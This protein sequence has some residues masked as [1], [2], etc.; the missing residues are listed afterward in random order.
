MSRTYRLRAAAAW[1]AAAALAAPSAARDCGIRE[2]GGATRF[3]AP[4]D[5][6]AALRAMV[7]SHWGEITRLLDAAGWPG[8]AEDLA[9]AVSGGR[10]SDRRFAT[11]T[12]F[13]WMMLRKNGAPMLLRDDCWGGAQPFEAF[14]F[15]VESDGRLWHFVVPKACGN[16][17][18]L[19]SEPLSGSAADATDSEAWRESE[20]PAAEAAPAGSRRAYSPPRPRPWW[21]LELFAGY[22]F[23]E[24]LDED[25][26]FGLRFGQVGYGAWGWLAAASWFDVADSQGFAGEDVDADIVHVDL[27]AVY[28]PRTLPGLALFF[29][30]GWASGNVD[31]PGSTEDLSDDA[32]TVHA[33]VG[34]EFDA[35][36]RFYLKPDLRARWYELEGWGTE[37]GRE[38]QVTY[39]VALALGW[40]FGR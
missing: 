2:L 38:N 17:A 12:Y 23:P 25:L 28:H 21:V 30:P 7:P 19:G 11:G 16:L 14:A 5:S 33:G 36:D 34:Y 8:D 1:I 13:E 24:E 26:A 18:L 10:I 27:S 39:E 20:P 6:V 40:R 29:G 4:L 31:V 22:F 35:T 9:D 37:G 15:D 32:F 3:V